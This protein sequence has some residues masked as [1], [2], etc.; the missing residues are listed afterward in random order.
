MILLFGNAIFGYIIGNFNE[1]IEDIKNL[2]QETDDEDQ[3]NSFFGLLEKFNKN[4]PL[5]S[6]VR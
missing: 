4:R 1:M 5:L 3:L 6:R 2:Y